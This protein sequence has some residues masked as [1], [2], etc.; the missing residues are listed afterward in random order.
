M[1]T[2]LSALLAGLTATLVVLLAGL[3][4]SQRRLDAR[5]AQIREE[6]QGSAMPADDR[7]L[8]GRL[9]RLLARVSPVSRGGAEAEKVRKA[10]RGAGLEEERHEVAY[11]AAVT[12]LAVALPGLSLGM[13]AGLSV[14]IPAPVWLLAVAL[15]ALV[16]LRLP[17]MW[18]F[19]RAKARSQ[20]IE[21]GIPELIDLMVICIEG[22]QSFDAALRRS[23]QD[24]QRTRPELAAELERTNLAIRAGSGRT[25]ALRDFAARTGIYDVRELTTMLIQADRS[26]VA[27]RDS[28]QTHADTMRVL[29]LQRA[30]E[31]A[32]KM[33]VK[34]IAPLAVCLLPALMMIL[35]GPAVMQLSKVFGSSLG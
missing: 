4:A 5:L 35:F 15:P 9:L 14:A 20:A 6:H 31:R 29:R 8:P 34:L 12:V 23:T 32:A 2:L 18:L 11:R 33:P 13:L 1:T 3:L 22:G 30:E 25:E 24:L 27:L 17:S 26:G 21:E 7:S 10:L 16:G 19:G 28:L